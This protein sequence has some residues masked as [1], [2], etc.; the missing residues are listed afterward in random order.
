MMRRLTYIWASLTFVLTAGSLSAQDEVWRFYEVTDTLIVEAERETRVPNYNTLATKLPLSLL[1]T[2]SSIGIVPSYL[3]EMQSGVVLSDAIQNVSGVNVQSNF[4][5]HDYFLIR[6]FNSLDNG[7]LMMD[8]TIEPEATYYNLY[9][10]ER[11]EVL[12]GP[13]AYLY[14]GNPLSGSINLN[15]KQ[16]IFRNFFSARGSFGHFETKRGTVDLGMASL[17]RGVAFRLNGLWQDSKNYRDNKANNS[18][19]VNPSFTWRINRKSDL[20]LNLEYIRNEYTPDSGL[21]ILFAGAEGTPVLPE[22]ERTNSYQTSKDFSEQ[23]NYRVRVDYSA[24]ASK[25]LTIRNKFYHNQLDW[26]SRGTLLNGAYPVQ[27]APQ[28]FD[29][30]VFRSFQSLDDRQVFFGNQL[31]AIA[32]FRTGAVQHHLLTGLE[33]ARY[34]DD[35]SLQFAELLPVRLASPGDTPI[36]L[37]SLPFLPFSQASARTTVIAPYFLNRSILSSHLHLLFGGRFD[38]FDYDD[39]RVDFDF[40]NMQPVPAQTER[41][42][43]HFSPM[44]GVNLLPAAPVSV[45]GNFGQAFA[46]PSTL[47]R[48]EPEPEESTQ[49]EVGAKAKF[50]DRRLNAAIAFYHLRKTNIAIPDQTGITRQTGDQRSRG[51]EL[52]LTGQPFDGWFAIA[53][54]AYADAEL[55]ELRQFVQGPTGTQLVDYSGNTPSFVPEHILNLWVTKEFRQRVGIGGGARYLSKQ[56]I[57]EDNLFSIDPVLTLDATVYYRMA[58]WRWSLNAKNI[59]N[60]EYLTRGFGSTAVIPAH[61][62]TVYGSLEFSL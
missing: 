48:G 8:G 33:I 24:R 19:A 12:K 47:T 28:T 39:D 6:G 49:F 27:V 53:S 10:I 29:N 17:P 52:E 41:S 42:Y 56:Y 37:E 15:R 59:T 44:V 1:Q 22:V 3:F 58:G 55:T 61:P 50:L 5:V 23:D 31:D 20:T 43:R 51:F 2:P 14:G 30:L 38:I 16:P 35:F 40:A 7:L 62:F 25:W 4:G 45:Y 54:Y 26:S 13:G 57:A 18:I 11:V 32:E 21:P 46:P 34:K 60:R 9:N 36:E